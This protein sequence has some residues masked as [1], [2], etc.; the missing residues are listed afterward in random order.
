[1]P[2]LGEHEIPAT[3]VPDDPRTV[4]VTPYA[5]GWCAVVLGIDNRAAPVTPDEA[6]TLALVLDAAADATERRDVQ[7]D[8]CDGRQR[9]GR[10]AAVLALATTLGTD[11]AARLPDPTPRSRAAHGRPGSSDHHGED[12]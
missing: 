3:A 9:D 8:T 6:R 2:A 7:D 5:H 11:P 4:R 10:A 12:S 1:L